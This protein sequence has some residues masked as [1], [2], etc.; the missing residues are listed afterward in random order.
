[1]DTEHGRV[2]AIIAA[3]GMG[4][5]M[6]TG[7]SKQRMALG[8]KAVLAHAIERLCASGVI[9]ECIVVVPPGET[10]LY[11]ALVQN[12]HNSARIPICCVEGG[13]DRMASIRNGLAQ[14]SST[15]TFV[16][17]HDGARPFVSLDT[18]L[19]CVEKAADTGAA[20]AAVPAKDTIK[21]AGE[22]GVVESTP[23]RSRLFQVQTPQVFRRDWLEEAH[24]AALQNGWSAT[25]DSALIERLGHKV[26]L[27][28]GSYFNLKITTPEDLVMAESILK[29]LSKKASGQNDMEREGSL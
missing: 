6:G 2:A 8:G 5:R 3:A 29:A 21:V 26:Y 9:A 24:L 22:D 23:D 13:S 28:R 25:D 4:T 12:V 17:I 1:M 27:V 15:A 7:V 11:E 20:V 10:A 19:N 16:L 18:I 14:V